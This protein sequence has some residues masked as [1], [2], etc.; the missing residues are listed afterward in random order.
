MSSR[1]PSFDG[2]AA[3]CRLFEAQ[4]NLEGVVIARPKNQTKRREELIDAAQRAIAT[5][6]LGALRLR[7]IADE[8][9]VTGPAVSYYYPDLDDLLVD[10]YQREMELLIK[11]GPEA[12]AGLVDPWEQLVVAVHQALP[13]GPDDVDAIITYLF[14]GEPKFART[15]NTMSA[16][17]HTSQESFFRSILDAGITTGAFTPSLDSATIARAI[18]A[19]SDS[20][21]LQVVFEERGMSRDMAADET[22][23]IAAALLGVHEPTTSLPVASANQA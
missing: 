16:A 12:I 22:L 1:R 13:T 17:L 3:C 15:Y 19:L 11:R 10:V 6:G 5:R 9:G 14:S 7:D 20:Y 21:G 18:I 23:R 2:P 8:A 4:N